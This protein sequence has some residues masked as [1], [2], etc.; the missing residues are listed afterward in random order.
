MSGVVT[1]FGGSGFIGRH[2]TQALA[3]RGCI[4]R[5]ATRD[6]E[7]ALITK[8]SGTVGQVVPMR[9]ASWDAASVARAVAGAD[10]A[11]NLVGTLYEK[12]KN[13]FE[14]THVKVPETI[15]RA[16]QQAGIR[17]FVH[18]SALGANVNSAS[19]YA[20][21]KAAGEAAVRAA[22]P[23]AVILRPSVIFGPEDHFF[24]RFARLALW[25]PVLPLIGGGQTRFQPVYVG[26]VAAA[27]VTTL[28]NATARGHLYEL[29]GPAVY[30][31][32]QLME[33]MLREIDRMPKLLTLSFNAAEMLAS[34]LQ[35]L[36]NPMLTR[37]QVALLRQD[38][39][40]TLRSQTLE[41]LGISSTSLEAVVPAYLAAYRTGGRF[42]HLAEA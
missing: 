10:A 32:R 5:V 3:R 40:V 8:T 28:D 1:L 22:H 20:R 41:T 39:I 27:I 11:V 36:P 17:H 7:R 31:F 37:D 25:S 35:I 34:V 6:P 38:N 12:D 29:G 26:D 9:C 13:T 4:V 33:F 15:A 16:C 30:R 2:L 24:N 19:V 42:A 14:R 18:L 21:S 23:D